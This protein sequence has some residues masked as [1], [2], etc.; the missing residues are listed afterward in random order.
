MRRKEVR[1]T[2]RMN[3]KHTYDE[4]KD[5]NY[6]PLC[7]NAGGIMRLYCKAVYSQT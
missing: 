1:T 5:E 6:L 7:I 3:D 2:E 4:R